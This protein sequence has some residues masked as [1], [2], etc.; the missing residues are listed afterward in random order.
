MVTV[1]QSHIE[2]CVSPDMPLRADSIL[3]LARSLIEA[4]MTSNTS[5]DVIDENCLDV[6]TSK[7]D[8]P[9]DKKEVDGLEFMLII[10]QFM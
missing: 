6:N 4:N 3:T 7:D 2:D 1:S 8:E 10:F 5:E 9:H